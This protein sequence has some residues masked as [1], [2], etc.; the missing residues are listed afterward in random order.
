MGLI[1]TNIKGA[2]SAKIRTKMKERAIGERI[3]REN[4]ATASR[5][6]LR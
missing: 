6:K 2:I 4:I 3:S 5:M 1:A